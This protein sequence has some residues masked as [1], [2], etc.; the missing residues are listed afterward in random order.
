MSLS[1]EKHFRPDEKTERELVG[2]YSRLCQAPSSDQ[3]E[4]VF[5]ARE[6]AI[7]LNPHHELFPSSPARAV[8]ESLRI[9]SFFFSEYPTELLVSKLAQIDDLTTLNVLVSDP[10]TTCLFPRSVLTALV[11]RMPPHKVF[12]LFFLF[13]P[14]VF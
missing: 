14:F 7:V 13:F 12:F 11:K 10:D 2:A 3:D 1:V 9:Q 6:L 8:A 5:A 4:L